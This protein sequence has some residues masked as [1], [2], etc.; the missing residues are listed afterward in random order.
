MSFA[1]RVLK[2]GLA[3]GTVLGIA[4]LGGATGVLAQGS[5]GT[6]PVVRVYGSISFNGANARTGA[7]VAAYAGSTQCNLST[8]SGTGHDYDGSIYAVDI[9]SS[10]AC[11]PT[12]TTITFQVDG[13]WA[14]QTL[15]VPSLPGGASRLDLTGPAASQPSGGAATGTASYQAGWN[16][17][18]G[19]TGTTFSQA[20]GVLYTFPAGAT[21]YQQVP[22]TQPVQA[23][24]GYWAYFSSA[25][26]VTLSGSGS[27]PM[28]VTAPP[29][30]FIMIGNPSATQ[31]V[32][33]SGAD[34]V[35][36]FDPVANNYSTGNVLKP[37]QGAW[38]YSFNGAT[39]TMQ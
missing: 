24:V 12:G 22:N 29:S 37:G 4:A 6:P 2:I 11:S 3:A 10:G 15:A 38:V 35:Y 17:V 31:T 23:G 21:D 16:L 32:T 19:P 5:P 34:A 27:V 13:K 20:V 26:T 14:N 39:I 8:T 7:V 33:V 36:T 18:A 9:P 25:T 1:Q 30:Q 28:T